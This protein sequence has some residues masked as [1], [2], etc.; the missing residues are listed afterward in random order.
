MVGVSTKDLDLNTPP[1]EVQKFWGYMPLCGRKYNAEGNLEDYGFSCKINDQIGVLLEFRNNVGQLQF[2]RNG[3]NCGV[4]FSNL[5]GPLYPAIIIYFGEAL[6][7][8][9]SKASVPLT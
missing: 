1:N 8:L 7:H 3:M 5:K 6:I 2:Y 9:D 4:A